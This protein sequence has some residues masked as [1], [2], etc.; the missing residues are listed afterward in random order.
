MQSTNLWNSENLRISPA[1]KARGTILHLVAEVVDL[2]VRGSFS[3]QRRPSGHFYKQIEVLGFRDGYLPFRVPDIK[4]S[5][6]ALKRDFDPPL[7]LTPCRGDP[8]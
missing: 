2:V 5:F 8:H 4:D 6:E 1:A 3:L 7:V